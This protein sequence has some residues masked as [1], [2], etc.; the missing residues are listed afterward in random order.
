MTCEEMAG[1]LAAY[2]DGE[3][4]AAEVAAVERHVAACAECARELRNGRR[5]N[6]LLDRQ[7]GSA[8]P[9]DLDERFAV[10]WQQTGTES[11]P[12]RVVRGGSSRGRSGFRRTATRVAAGALAAGLAL[13]VWWMG[14]GAKA[15]SE[16]GAGPSTQVEKVVKPAVK[17]VAQAAKP[18]PAPEAA[19]A[20]ARVERAAR[21]DA[22][23]DPVAQVAQADGKLPR[24]VRRRAAM[25]LDYSIVRRLDELENFDRVMATGKATDDRRS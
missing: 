15:P 16:S 9:E 10:L 7:L 4:I 11:R 21:P 22:K 1:Q 18:R 25:F 3:L 14:P 12:G 6:A 23:T 5:L 24:D 2:L 17:P 19:T 13:G 20:V 8:S